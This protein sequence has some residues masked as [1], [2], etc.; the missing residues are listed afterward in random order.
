MVMESLSLNRFFLAFRNLWIGNTL[1]LITIVPALF[2]LYELFRRAIALR[3]FPVR[4]AAIFAALGAVA[5]WVIFG[6]ARSQEYQF[7]Y[8]LFVPIIWIAIRTGYNG[9][10]LALPTLHALL[11]IIAS[12]L[13]Y[14]AYDFASFQLLMIVLSG[15]GLLLGAAVTDARISTERLRSQESELLR[16]QRHALVGA[17]GTAL[18]HEISQ[19]L[20]S[21]TNYLHETGQAFSQ[22]FTP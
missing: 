6:L 7:F 1:G 15:T 10:G 22:G 4:D 13:G 2:I 12:Y 5:F 21:T 8:L 18:A 19:P 16:A 17:T 14:T 9:V 20:V 11:V 3:D